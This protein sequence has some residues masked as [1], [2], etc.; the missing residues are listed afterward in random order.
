MSGESLVASTSIGTGLGDWTNP[1]MPAGL[2]AIKRMVFDVRF[3]T[4][5]K[6]W[7]LDILFR[8][9]VPQATIMAMHKRI[10]EWN[11]WHIVQLPMP[12][13]EAIISLY[14]HVILGC[15]RSLHQ[16]IYLG[17]YLKRAC[18]IHE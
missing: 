13:W 2:R 9:I 1:V 16:L 6:L 5:I 8:V 10:R 4:I 7:E 15:L 18:S 11:S 12:L 3:I 14:G 17:R